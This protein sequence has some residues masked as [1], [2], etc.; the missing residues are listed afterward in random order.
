MASNIPNIPEPEYVVELSAVYYAAIFGKSEE[1]KKDLQLL[2]E[3]FES[4][5]PLEKIYL[6]QLK[7]SALNLAHSRKKVNS[8]YF[9]RRDQ[10]RKE[11][12]NAIKQTEQTR[13][14]SLGRL[15]ETKR[16]IKTT[17]QSLVGAIPTYLL[18]KGALSQE[19]AV[20]SG[21]LGG[22]VAG[23]VLLWYGRN[24]KDKAW[25]KHD[26]VVNKI[27]SEYAK[28][29][30]ALESMTDAWRRKAY[31]REEEKLR[32]S[33]ERFFDIKIETTPSALRDQYFSR[34]LEPPTMDGA[35]AEMKKVP[36]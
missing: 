23:S 8:R 17:G 28:K 20:L 4:M 31:L 30:E 36:R 1:A 3:R 34:I 5:K 14:R 22:T 16:F 11:R 12:D 25:E 2:D 15:G 24:D 33:Y 32:G 27:D 26:K 10:L 29:Y 35:L 9:V 19:D 18:A 6:H 7:M 21:V 13:D